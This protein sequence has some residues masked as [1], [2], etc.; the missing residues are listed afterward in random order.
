[1]N[2]YPSLFSHIE[3]AHDVFDLI[4]ENDPFMKNISQS[5]E[6]LLNK[7]IS[8]QKNLLRILGR[9]DSVKKISLIFI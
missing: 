9:L 3:D 7:G 5:P 6:L 4:F 1:M 8:K 2:E